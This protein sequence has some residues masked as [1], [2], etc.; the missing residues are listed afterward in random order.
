MHGFYY[1]FTTYIRSDN[2]AAVAEAI[3]NLLS[4]EEG[5]YP[6]PQLPALKVEIEKLRYPNIGQRP[7]LLITGLGIGQQGWT[8]VKTY[9]NEWLF[10][11][12]PGSD[13]PRLSTLTMRLEC[14][15]FYYRVV[16]DFD[17]LLLETD[18]KGIFRFNSTESPQFSLIEVPESFQQAM[19]VNQNPEILRIKALERLSDAEILRE[20]EGTMDTQQL[21]E[22]GSELQRGDAERTDIALAK[23]IDPFQGRWYCFDLF[24]KAYTNYQQLEEMNVQLLYFQPPENYLRTLPRYDEETEEYWDE[25]F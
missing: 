21:A 8:I 9:P 10:L 24:Y 15:A 7:P 13:R 19:Q 1:N 25:E 16:D 6:L 22:L 23:E 17:G 3:I 14:D 20:V 12:A 18:A 11:R 5:C 4:Q 2:Q